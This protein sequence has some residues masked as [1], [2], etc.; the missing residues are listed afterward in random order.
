M[1]KP[2]VDPTIYQ[3]LKA[4]GKL[5]RQIADMLDVNEASVRRGLKKPASKPAVIRRVTV[6][7]IEEYPQA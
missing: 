3:A 2:K 4:Q 5:N 6:F 1:S 7:V